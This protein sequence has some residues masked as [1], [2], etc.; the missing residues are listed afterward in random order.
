MQRADDCFGKPHSLAYFHVSQ[1][2]G[3]MNGPISGLGPVTEGQRKARRPPSQARRIL[4]RIDAAEATATRRLT[5]QA[6]RR[7]G[8]NHP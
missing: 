4:F 6:L 5:E 8:A 3:E 1:Q 2:L 7:F